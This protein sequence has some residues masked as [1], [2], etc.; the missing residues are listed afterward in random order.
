MQCSACGNDPPSSGPRRKTRKRRA[1]ATHGGRYLAARRSETE[2]EPGSNGRVLANL[3]GIRSA[4]EMARVEQREFIRTAHY[5]VQQYCG[6]QRL[7][8]G[9]LCDLH[10][11]W[12]GTLYPWAGE[13][14]QVNLSKGGFPF[15][16]A[17]LVPFLMGDFEENCLAR[18]SDLSRARSVDPWAAL[19]EAHTEFLLI[20]PFRD[21]NGR[22]ARL[23]TTLMALRA[24]VPVPSFD[25]LRKHQREAYFAAVRAGLDRNYEPMRRVLTSLVSA[26]RP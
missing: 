21:G 10:R 8:A 20:H 22:V 16:A 25:R 24:G 5:A 11:Q 26:D 9:H 2:Y 17:R 19:A 12:L 18:Y 4:R 3:L 14:R 1:R 13:Y 6:A 7:T 15:A 23:L